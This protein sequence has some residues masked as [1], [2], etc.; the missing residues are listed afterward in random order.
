[1]TILQ[2]TKEKKT[3]LKSYIM[4]LK[5]C[6]SVDGI[7]DLAKEIQRL[8]IEIMILEQIRINKQ[9]INNESYF[10]IKESKII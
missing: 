10:I 9:I 5:F 4:F 8:Q 3:L 1:M 7:I 2:Q 6:R